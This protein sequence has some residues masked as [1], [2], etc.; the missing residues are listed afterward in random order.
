MAPP[1][2]LAL[3]LM[4]RVENMEHRAVSVTRT[5]P[6]PVAKL[7]RNVDDVNVTLAELTAHKPP[8]E[9]LAMLYSISH[10]RNTG[11]ADAV[12]NTAPPL[13]P[14]LLRENLTRTKAGDA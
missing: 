11:V 10:A 12:T 6:A 14:A 1:R 3:L 8:P 13:D 7:P 4:N 2:F 9:V 5:A